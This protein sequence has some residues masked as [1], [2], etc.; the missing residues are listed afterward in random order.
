MTGTRQFLRRRRATLGAGAAVLLGASV[1]QFTGVN[2]AV[3]QSLALTAYEAPAD[4][5][6][7]PNAKAWADAAPV[8]VPL[9][10]QAGSYAAGGGSIPLVRAKALHY[11]QKLFVRVE[12]Q[13][14]TKDETTA[15]VQDF[16]DAVALEFPATSSAAVPA[17][18]MGQADGGVN[19]WQWRADSQVGV[20]DPQD[21]YVGALVDRPP[22]KAHD[23]VFYTARD[24]GNPYA[25]V[26][27][28]P[29]QTLISQALGTI[30]K[31]NVQDVAG[32][33]VHTNGT[34]AVV[35]ERPFTAADVSQA[36]FSAGKTTDLAIAVWNGSEG[37][38]N[39]RKS[40]S[41]FVRLSVASTD[42]PNVERE[43]RGTY[44]LAAGALGLFVVAGAGL[45]FFG[46]RQGGTK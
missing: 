32:N 27:A 4:P 3:S 13:D 17:L 2:P 23:I 18:C 34:W 1:L 15:R 45:G 35:F 14:S 20:K 11:N 30:S 5:G 40:V 22:D 31:A 38:R 44:L 12:W 9:T 16:A 6:L 41:Q 33:G 46:Y 28:G 36:A 29:V 42:N 7:D 10:A 25:D 19:I 24:A 43:T 8:Q 26:Q 39:G 37:D 21:V